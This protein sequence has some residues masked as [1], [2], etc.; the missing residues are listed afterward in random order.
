MKKILNIDAE[1]LQKVTSQ[2][3]YMWL[4]VCKIFH[5]WP[6]FKNAFADLNT[7]KTKINKRKLRMVHSK[8]LYSIHSAD[9]M[10]VGDL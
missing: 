3:D 4:M 7:E 8:K 10:L 6:I 1:W 2:I 9:S 5:G